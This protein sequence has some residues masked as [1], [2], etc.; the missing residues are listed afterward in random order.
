MQGLSRIRL[1][2]EDGPAAQEEIA[3]LRALLD[4]LKAA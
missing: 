4:E 2:L 3:R 1:Y